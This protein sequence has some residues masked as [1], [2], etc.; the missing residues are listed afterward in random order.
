MPDVQ[1]YENIGKIND[2][3]HFVFSLDSPYES[4]PVSVSR[5]GVKLIADLQVDV[6]GQIIN[7]AVQI[8][9]TP[10]TVYRHLG[11]NGKSLSK[12][13]FLKDFECMQLNTKTLSIVFPFDK[14]RDR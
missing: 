3:L 6:P 11:L 9:T 8:N 13:M 14:V 1:K 7:T 12:V 10:Q 5:V 4:S 2:L